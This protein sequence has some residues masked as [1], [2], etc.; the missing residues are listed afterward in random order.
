MRR[1]TAHGLTVAQRLLDLED[2]AHAFGQAARQLRHD[3]GEH[4]V[5]P[6]QRR[7]QRVG[8]TVL[9]TPAGGGEGQQRH[10]D[11]P[12]RSSARRQSSTSNTPASTASAA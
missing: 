8:Q 12:R 2:E 1:G 7:R 9:C 6:F 5:L 4:D 3:A 10:G 11:A